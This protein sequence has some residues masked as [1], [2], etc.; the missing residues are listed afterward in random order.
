M[1]SSSFPYMWLCVIPYILT[2]IP[3]VFVPYLQYVMITYIAI[4]YLSYVTFH[5]TKFQVSSPVSGC[6]LF[7]HC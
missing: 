6:V 5:C 1:K 3:S 7:L 2:S 4:D